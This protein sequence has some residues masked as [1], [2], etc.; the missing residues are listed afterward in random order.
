MKEDVRWIQR[1]DNYQKALSQLQNGVNLAAERE[2]SELEKQGLIQAFE[3][4]HELGWKTLRDFLINRGQQDIYG[5]KDTTRLAVNLGLIHN[6]TIWMDMIKSRNE[7]VHTY[8]ENTV[9]TI[10]KKII[11][12]Y[13]GEFEILKQKLIR[14]KKKYI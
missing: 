2:L 8:N 11:K 13:A 1:L 3:Y 7:T 5:S 14:E 10:F 4:T 9:K 6:G 12:E